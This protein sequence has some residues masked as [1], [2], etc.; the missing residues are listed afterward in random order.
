MYP[1]KSKDQ[2]I[3]QNQLKT[4]RTSMK[5]IH[6]QNT[7]SSTVYKIIQQLILT[8][9]KKHKRIVYG[10]IALNAIMKH[11]TN[12]QHYTEHD[13]P[14]I[15]FYSSK[16]WSDAKAICDML[17]NIGF[18]CEAKEAIHHN[19][20]SIHVNNFNCCDITFYHE[21]ILATM[22]TIIIN[23]IKYAHP[24]HMYID[25]INIMNLSD[26]HGF[27]DK[28]LPKLTWI[29]KN[30]PFKDKKIK[31]N[32]NN[33]N[34]LE[35]P[36]IL[37]MI[38]KKSL[39]MTDSYAVHEYTKHVQ[40]TDHRLSSQLT[41]LS[42]ELLEDAMHV[43]N[44]LMKHNKNVQVIE[45]Y[46]FSEYIGHKVSF[47]TDSNIVI[48]LIDTMKLAAP[49]VVVNEVQIQAI[50]TLHQY[51]LKKQKYFDVLLYEH[52]DKDKSKKIEFLKQITEYDENFLRKAWNKFYQT[53]DIIVAKPHIFS[54]FVINHVGYHQSNFL[55]NQIEFQA[56][57]KGK[58]KGMA[59][60]PKYQPG[61]SKQLPYTYKMHSRLGQQIFSIDD[62]IVNWL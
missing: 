22:S 7:I 20:I 46:E 12:E 14:D 29:V 44:V 31:L 53:H 4:I 16:P 49:Y 51:L 34:L 38:R 32:L 62:K 18:N 26:Q 28:T 50:Q 15:E 43:Y 24:H 19:T 17:Y 1:I 45:Y 37:K 47:H 59:I 27:Y 36:W 11:T 21:K 23:G 8:Y 52:K 35:I 39:V 30:Y 10:G 58:K 57:I 3:I 48:T 60:K 5:Q 9:S 2:Q 42:C 56:R 25:Y 33:K 6:N 40:L 13:I 55:K 54:I 61:V 41:L